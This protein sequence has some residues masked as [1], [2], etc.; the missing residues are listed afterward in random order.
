MPLLQQINDVVDA[1]G[2]ALN[3]ISPLVSVA[4]GWS[5]WADKII[6]FINDYESKWRSILEETSVESYAQWPT[7]KQKILAFKAE[8]NALLGDETTSPGVLLQALSRASRDY[9]NIGSVGPWRRGKST[10]LDQLTHLGPWIIPMS[11]LDKCTG[12]TI[13][14][15]NDSYRVVND[16]EESTY[17]H[18][19]V[20]H[21]YTV[22]EMCDILNEY[23]TTLGISLSANKSSIKTKDQFHQFCVNNKEQVSAFNPQKGQSRLKNTLEDY[24]C[25]SDEYAC[26]LDGGKHIIYDLLSDE[27]KRE[28]CPLVSYRSEP[29][30][31]RAYKVLATKK[32]DVFTRFML[33][34]EDV[35]K[36]Q[37]VDT[38]GIGEERIGVDEALSTALRKDLDIA[39]ALAKVAP[40]IDDEELV[41]S[42]HE[43]LQKE[44]KGRNP[45]KWLFYLFNI[46]STDPQID[47]S[48][49]N[50][51]RSNV[52]NSL[53]KGYNEGSINYPGIF[54][55]DDHVE[56][57]D[58]LIDRRLLGSTIDGKLRMSEER[59]IQLFIKSILEKM[60][61][62][63]SA[64]DETFYNEAKREYNKVKQL[65]DNLINDL[66]K[67]AVNSYDVNT[68]IASQMVTVYKFLHSYQYPDITKAIEQNISQ[69]VERPTGMSLIALYN[70]SRDGYANRYTSDE[71]AVSELKDI[72]RI[73]WQN[74]ECLPE[75]KYN[76]HNEFIF[77][78]SAKKDLYEYMKGEIAALINEDDCR[79]RMNKKKQ[80]IAQAF[81]TQGKMGEVVTTDPVSFFEQ[82][83]V[84][85]KKKPNEY[86]NLIEEFTKFIAFDITVKSDVKNYF[87]VALT[88]CLH[89][90]D[91]GQYGFTT[92]DAA[93]LSLTHSLYFMEQSIK[94]SVSQSDGAIAKVIKDQQI[95][96]ENLLTSLSTISED[97]PHKLN[98]AKQELSK[99]YNNHKDQIFSHDDSS[100]KQAIVDKWNALI[101]D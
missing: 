41:T 37:F 14:I 81:I 93:L 23:F 86:P 65:Y 52:L 31:E 74:A 46:H 38:P 87:D 34:G 56:C 10:L 2:S 36:I 78:T 101:F 30:G 19:A 5:A 7:L 67:L 79:K 68:I 32:A 89:D 75:A 47:Y 94:D 25:H 63:I 72:L 8:V 13:N 96:F 91:F 40:A 83:L 71:S 21:R 64:V 80:E 45:E 51:I 77:Y 99:F 55:A 53:S 9:L 92:Y 62:A 85:L 98:P 70:A 33:V 73:V 48:V 88:T 66:K 54:L 28:Y 44:L 20:I 90:D 57:I 42:F 6:A 16:G 24:M 59:G 12:T 49:Y 82:L 60:V 29:D 11:R 39:I 50:N 35:G 97:F 4:K 76:Q 61:D 15:I 1:R 69:M 26:L 18:V 84:L 95:K 43:K 27:S 100:I 17:D 22:D 58:T 3:T